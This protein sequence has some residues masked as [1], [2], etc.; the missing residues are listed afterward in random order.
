MSKNNRIL[1][2]MTGWIT[3]RKAAILFCSF[4]ILCQTNSFSQVITNTG[5][6]VSVRG[7]T[8]I[9]ARD[10]L[11]NAGS[12]S[13]SGTINLSG[14]YSNTGLTSGSTGT[15]RLGGNW[16]N[17]GVFA[18][19]TSTVIF[20]GSANQVITRPGGETFNNLAVENSG[21]TGGNTIGLSHNVTV[22]N[23]LSISRGNINSGIS[24]L[25]LF[26]PLPSALN[27]TSSTGS[28]IIGKFERGVNQAATYL[29]PL[30]TTAN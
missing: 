26:N 18:W 13:N 7:G 4:L 21:I 28:R 8:V 24:K 17:N 19:G 1:P 27:Y 23:T 29:F 22:M 15:F 9:D 20:N 3:T 16:T 6:V 12:L 5:A 30:G 11:N 25:Y 14:N 10:I 2:L